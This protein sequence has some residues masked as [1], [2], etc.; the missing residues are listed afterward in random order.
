MSQN[1][2]VLDIPGFLSS[3][4]LTQFQELSQARQFRFCSM[5]FYLFLFQHADKF[6]HLG[7]DR[8]Y[9]ENSQPRPVF[10]WNFSVRQLPKGEGYVNLVNTFMSIAYTIIHDFPSP[11]VFPEMKRWLQAGKYQCT[12]DWFL[13]EDCTEIRVYEIG[14]AHV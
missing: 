10:D 8:V 2:V 6:D 9:S 1:G 14:R 13:F 5:V 4:I 12:G 7:F 3:T 11:R